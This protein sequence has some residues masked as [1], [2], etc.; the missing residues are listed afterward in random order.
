M[1]AMK[2]VILLYSFNIKLD[3]SCNKIW[4]HAFLGTPVFH[5]TISESDDIV[6][7]EENEHSLQAMLNIADMFANN[8]GLSF[9]SKKSQVL[10]IGKKVTDKDWFLSN[11][12]IK[13][14]QAYKYFGTIIN[15]QLHDTRHIKDHLA[16]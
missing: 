5:V 1:A 10:I 16:Y 9:N 11:K 2:I 12:T 8:W 14:T 3:S 6:L 7:F 15:R 13:E 4:C